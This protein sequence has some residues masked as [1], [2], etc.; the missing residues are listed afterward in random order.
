MVQ[1]GFCS[2][3]LDCMLLMSRRCIS[4]CCISWENILIWLCSANVCC[5]L[6]PKH[7][8]MPR[9][10]VSFADYQCFVFRELVSCIMCIRR[11]RCWHSPDNCKKVKVQLIWLFFLFSVFTSP[12]LK[13]RCFKH[14]V[15][16]LYST[17]C[18][19]P[20]SFWGWDHDQDH[21]SAL[22]SHIMWLWLHLSFLFSMR[23]HFQ[24]WPHHYL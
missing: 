7:P 3:Q 24:H 17:I 6:A 15:Y 10:W 9:P 12:L 18:K 5:E 20:Q 16:L 23:L 11:W 8:P 2:F 22:L 1:I 4:V 14:Y 13:S 19:G 21:W